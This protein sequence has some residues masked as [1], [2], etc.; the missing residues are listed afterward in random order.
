M[1]G[2]DAAAVGEWLADLDDAPIPIPWRGEVYYAKPPDG[3]RGKRIAALMALSRG[4]KG[5][6]QAEGDSAETDRTMD[7]ILQGESVEVLSIGRETYDALVDAGMPPK[8]QAM[9]RLSTL[10]LIR[11][12]YGS[13]DIARNY[14]ESFKDRSA[15]PEPET[16]PAP[17]SRARSG[18]KTSSSTASATRT[19]SRAGTRTTPSPKE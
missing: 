6:D 3:A 10:C 5:E 11:W 12:A 16:P 18:R 2:L 15:E 4:E 13:D 17:K 9:K 7:E 14:L 1:S 8:S 19:R